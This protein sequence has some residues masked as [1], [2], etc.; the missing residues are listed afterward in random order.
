MAA[1]G[2]VRGDLRSVIIII[3]VIIVIITTHHQLLRFIDGGAGGGQNGC[4]VLITRS[5]IWARRGQTRTTTLSIMLGAR[6]GLSLSAAATAGF[7]RRSRS[8][9]VGEGERGA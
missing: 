1:D 9:F 8:G 6:A 2:I 4:I 3:I 5:A 7:S